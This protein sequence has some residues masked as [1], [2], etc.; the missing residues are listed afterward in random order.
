MLESIIHS[1]QLTYS[2]KDEEGVTSIVKK[3]RQ[4]KSKCYL[5]FVRMIMVD[6][7]GQ[8]PQVISMLETA[9]TVDLAIMGES[10]KNSGVLSLQVSSEKRVRSFELKEVL[11]P[12]GMYQQ[13][14]FHVHCIPL[15]MYR[16]HNIKGV[17]VW[18]FIQSLG[19]LS[20]LLK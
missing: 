12:Q 16:E 7:S 17:D 10:A 2:Q 8:T 18:I 4:L 19:L 20:I 14:K 5:N 13:L 9:T 1:R 6:G 15:E 11:L 3:S